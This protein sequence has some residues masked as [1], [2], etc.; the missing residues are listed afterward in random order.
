M[1]L[2]V[3]VPGIALARSL[4]KKM[5]IQQVKVLLVRYPHAADLPTRHPTQDNTY[6]YPYCTSAS[7]HCLNKP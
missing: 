1:M 3:G 6:R 5:L 2:I 4:M 7:S